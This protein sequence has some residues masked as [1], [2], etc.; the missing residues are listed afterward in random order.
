MLFTMKNRSGFLFL[1][2]LLGTLGKQLHA[3]KIYSTAE[4]FDSPFASQA[5]AWLE[6]GAE[7]WPDGESGNKSRIKVYIKVWVKRKDMTRGTTKP[8]AVLHDI[9]GKVVGGAYL[10]LETTHDTSSSF[11]THCLIFRGYIFKDRVDPKS[12][13]ETELAKI[14]DPK[15]SKVDTSDMNPFLRSFSFKTV[16]D[17]LGFVMYEMKGKEGPRMSLVFKDGRLVAV[18]PTT[19]ITLKHFVAELKQPSLHIVYFEKLKEDDENL[20]TEVFTSR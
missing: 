2:V 17:T 1:F 16:Q 11:S 10:P 14:L 18:V 4:L 3:E 15:K 7:V 6:R 8:N 20:I 19:T 12:I 13:P 9:N 5:V